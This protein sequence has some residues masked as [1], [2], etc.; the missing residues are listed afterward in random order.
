METRRLGRTG[1][2]VS[3]IG[4]G[5]WGLSGEHWRDTDP[6]AGRRALYVALESGITFVDTALV[7]GRGESERIVGEVVR[8]MRARD[9]VVVASK[10]PPANGRWPARA[11]SSLERVFP[12]EHV[13]RSVEQSLRNLRLEAIP[14]VQLHVWLDEWLDGSYWPALRGC[15]ERLVSEGKVLHWGISANDHS[16]ATALRV[17]D[18]PIIETVQVIYNLF[19]RGPEE[20]LFARAAERSVGVIVR[21]PFDE[22]ALTGA[23]GPESLFA[24][25]DFRSRY[26]KDDRPTQVADRVD[27]L[28]PLL[29]DEASTLPE[30]AL[31]FTLSRREVSTVIPGMRRVEHVRSNLAVANGRRL[32]D[33]LL[34]ELAGHAWDK[35]WYE[36]G[37]PERVGEKRAED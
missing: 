36:W 8:T 33:R 34:E 1:S 2:E 22:G 21:C 35:N 25:G 20:A 10:V 27:K 11:G 3:A 30:L 4:F 18:E 29:G 19:D 37:P 24:P 26:F 6:E 32:T 12:D 7:Y 5:G 13:T 28:R 23:I 15:M 17:L 16:P 14:V 9:T 31:R